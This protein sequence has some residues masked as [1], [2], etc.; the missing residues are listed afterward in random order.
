M[1][2]PVTRRAFR[3]WQRN[4][5]VYRRNWRNRIAFSVIEPFTWR[6]R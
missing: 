5:D 4:F 3:V 2:L 1:S 6:A